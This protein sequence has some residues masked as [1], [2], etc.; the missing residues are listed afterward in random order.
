ML[1]P[2]QNDLQED[3]Y[4][5]ASG[6]GSATNSSSDGVAQQNQNNVENDNT[7]HSYCEDDPWDKNLFENMQLDEVYIYKTYFIVI[8]K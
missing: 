4:L 1:L 7:N 5:A 8:Q 6:G 2:K 3:K